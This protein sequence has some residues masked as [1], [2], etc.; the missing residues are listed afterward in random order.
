MNPDAGTRLIAL[1]GDPVAHSLSPRFQN[2]AIRHA[3]LDAVYL[4]LRCDKAAL[5]GLL[6]GITGACGAGNITIPHKTAAVPHLDAPT[7]AVEATGACN[8]FWSEGG[9]LHGDNTDVEGFAAACRAL[10]GPPAGARVLVLGA[11]GA[12][13]A[14]VV[15]L[16]DARVD[17]VRVLNRSAE[18][19]RSLASTLDRRGRKVAVLA[20]DADLR[21]EGFDLVVNATPLGLREDDPL[22]LDLEAP[23][24]V[25]AALDLVYHPGGTR[26]TA[27]AARFD[28]PAAD[29]T[30]MLLHQGAAAFRRWF[31]QE[32]P[33]EVMRGA[34]G[35]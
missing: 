9:R 19:A 26:W 10:I 25:G 5:P 21:R 29:G 34:L 15:A 3:G 17:A 28:I 18:R 22:P 27:E 7:P 8:T 12:A 32:A 13:R 16:L 14:A 24:R 2:A 6:E 30:E 11:G 4:A 35:G 31:D 20:P 23:A 1:L 33:L